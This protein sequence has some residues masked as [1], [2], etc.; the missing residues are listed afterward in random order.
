MRAALALVLAVLIGLGG[1][2]L[3]SAQTPPP[4]DPPQVQELVKLLGD[5]AVREWLERQGI[6]SRRTIPSRSISTMER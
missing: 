2:G 3:T 4:R 5:P 1:S 6:A